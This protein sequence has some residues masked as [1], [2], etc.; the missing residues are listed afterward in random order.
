[1]SQEAKILTALDQ[2]VLQ[3]SATFFPTLAEPGFGLIKACIHLYAEPKRWAVVIERLGY[4]ERFENF[5]VQL[6]YFGDCLQG[7]YLHNGEPSNTAYFFPVD[8]ANLRQIERGGNLRPEAK[9]LEIR[10]QKIP[11]T[12]AAEP[13]LQ[14][15]ILPSPTSADPPSLLAQGR[16]W[17]AQGFGPL[18]AA[19]E[20]ELRTHL[21]SDL[22]YLCLIDQYHHR[23]YRRLGR[24]TITEADMDRHWQRMME[25]V[26]SGDS[27][28]ADKKIASPAYDGTAPSTCETWQQ[29]AKVLTFRD[30]ALYQPT[31]APNNHWRDQL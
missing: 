13:Y 3:S 25:R 5:Q 28:P 19:K 14:E 11:L 12:T 29:I 31:E 9:I 20:Q 22:P 18:F 6:S 24:R 23:D 16:L 8:L 1:M 21:P 27:T 2:S 7:Q 26:E 15:K 17:Q 4:H 10:G 30:A